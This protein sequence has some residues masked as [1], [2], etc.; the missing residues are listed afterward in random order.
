MRRFNLRKCDLD[1]GRNS[2]RDLYSYYLWPSQ[3]LR[4]SLCFWRHCTLRLPLG[5]RQNDNNHYWPSG[6][7]LLG[8]GEG[9][10]SVRQCGK[11]YGN[12]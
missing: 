12:G 7:N 6:W 11:C 10:Q 8:N 4:I 5:Q 2:K 1:R 3:W 9:R